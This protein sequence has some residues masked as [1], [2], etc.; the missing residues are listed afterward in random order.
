MLYYMK[1]WISMPWIN[2][3]TGTTAPSKEHAKIYKWD[4]DKCEDTD[5]NVCSNELG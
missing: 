5:G 2:V 1:D 3:D 4:E